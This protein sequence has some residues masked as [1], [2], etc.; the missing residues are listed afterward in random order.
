MTEGAARPWPAQQEPA[1]Q[2]VPLLVIDHEPTHA[3]LGID[4]FGNLSEIY[5][6]E[7]VHAVHTRPAPTPLGSNRP[8]LASPNC[9]GP[10]PTRPHTLKPNDRRGREP[11]RLGRRRAGDRVRGRALSRGIAG[12]RAIEAPA[13][14]IVPSALAGEPKRSSPHTDLERRPAASCRPRPFAER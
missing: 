8:T 11:N 6:L 4:R 9:Q 1:C 13:R 3:D 10:S 14:G 2:R 12:S 7:I 5:N